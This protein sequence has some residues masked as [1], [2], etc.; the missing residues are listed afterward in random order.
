MSPSTPNSE[1]TSEAKRALLAQ[2]LQQKQCQ[3]EAAFPLSANQQA[4]W[5][6]YK[7]APESWAY[8]VLFSAC[9][10][11]E[12]DGDALERSFQDLV[13]RHPSLRTTY[14]AIEG[15]PVQQIQPSAR[16]HFIRVD[17]ADLDDE[18]LHDRLTSEGQ[19]PFDLERGSVF[20]VHLF[21]RSAADHVLLL[22]VHHVAVDLW[23]LTVLL[24]ELRVAYAAR[25][26][27]QTPSLPPLAAQYSDFVRKQAHWLD[28]EDGDRLLSYWKQQLEGELPL[29]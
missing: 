25:V 11:S 23:S 12:V 4:L 7:L 6:L 26:A 15:S 9:I 5:F 19:R 29:L 10:R 14:T 18:Q 1:L 3:T 2:L 13:D 8:N 24:D 27:K 20:R 22:A 17:A 28:G 21:S 16:V